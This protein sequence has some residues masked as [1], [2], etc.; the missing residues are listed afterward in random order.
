M[1]LK[2]KEMV[3]YYRN[4][5]VS[6]QYTEKDVY[7]FLMLLRPYSEE[8]T[9]L[10][11]FA[12]FV[13]HRNKDRES[14]KEYVHYVDDIM[15]NLEEANTQMVIKPVYTVH[16]VMNSLNN[17]LANFGNIS[18]NYEQSKDILFCIMILLQEC[19]LYRNKVEFAKLH[20]GIIEDNIMLL[21][22][23]KSNKWDSIVIQF[24]IL[25]LNNTYFDV[26]DAKK[27]E[28]I[29]SDKFRYITRLKSSDNSLVMEFVQTLPVQYDNNYKYV[30]LLSG[31][32]NFEKAVRNKL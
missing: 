27:R 2:E 28:F 30:L 21:A 18:L 14:I 26:E 10:R 4:R 5:I 25:E 22:N 31:T 3:Y 8:K 19:Y 1:D 29:S 23:V 16:D 13:A 11:E 17:A 20:L 15:N 9:A 32:F 6:K 12:N 24:P 7:A